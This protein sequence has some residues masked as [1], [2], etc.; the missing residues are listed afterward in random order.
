[1]VFAAAASGLPLSVAAQTEKRS[2]RVAYLGTSGRESETFLAFSD[3]LRSFGF[4]E[5][6]NLQVTHS[7]YV[8]DLGSLSLKAAE[9]VHATPDVLVAD[10]PETV[11]RALRNA[12]STIPIVVVAVNYDPIGRGYGATLAHPGG[13]VTGIYFR[14]PELVGKQLG[15]LTEMVP[16]ATRVAVLWGAEVQDEFDAAQ[17]A[18]PLLGLQIEPL[19]LGD[20]PYDFEAAFRT[21]AERGAPMALIL[22]TPYFV[23]HRQ[24]VAGL[25][26]RYGLPA[27][28]RFRS[29]VAAGG[30]LSYGVDSADMRRHAA[31]HVAKILKGAKP[32]DLPIEQPTKFGLS[33][34]LK[35]AKALGV[36]VP[37]IML[38]QADEVI[39]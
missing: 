1:L 5:N 14:S 24:E 37:Q 7:D 39:E 19:K 36:T 17:L 35:T 9:F 20:P 3:E 38:A 8:A 25:T 15:L 33:I 16:G 29:Y 21:I 23:P 22:S 26:I 13:N 32:A 27:L 34:N 30:L 2:A 31:R 6:R 11:V 12:T 28:F 10:G 18:A 4:D